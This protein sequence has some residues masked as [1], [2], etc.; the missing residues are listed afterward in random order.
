[1]AEAKKRI[2]VVEDDESIILGLRMNLEAEGYDVICRHGRR[3]R[4]WPRPREPE[5]SL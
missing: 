3:E 4:A 2:L 5:V 1:M